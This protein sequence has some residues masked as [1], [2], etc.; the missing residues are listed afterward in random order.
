MLDISGSERLYI[1]PEVFHSTRRTSMTGS[2]VL[3]ITYGVNIQPENDPLINLAERNV[4]RF[5]YAGVP[6]MFLVVRSFTF[7]ML[8]TEAKFG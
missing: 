7:V 4:E 3:R 5:L 2:V 6:G 1:S 8:M